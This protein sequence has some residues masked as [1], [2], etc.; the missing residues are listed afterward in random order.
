[1]GHVT[2]F[3]IP[4]GLERVVEYIRRNVDKEVALKCPGC[5]NVSNGTNSTPPV[6]T[7]PIVIP[8]III[9]GNPGTNGSG[10]GTPPPP[11]G[12]DGTTVC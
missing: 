9:P 8:P 4:I 1:L 7:P 10:S 5:V 6:V 11:S 3:G 12:G 2:S